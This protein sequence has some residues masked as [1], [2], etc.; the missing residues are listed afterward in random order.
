MPLILLLIALFSC[1]KQE[2]QEP[3]YVPSPYVIEI[4]WRFPA[5]VNIPADNPMTI[6]GVELGRCLF[7]DGR[8]SG[9]TS[10]DSLMSCS[11][12]HLQSH[13][14]EC[15]IDHP[16]FAGGHPFGVTGIP[17]AH[18]M[19]P[20]INLVWTGNGYLWNGSVHGQ[21]ADKNSRNIEDIVSMAIVTPSEMNSDTTRVKTLI[22]NIPGYPELFRKAFGG[23]TV[24]MK[25]ISKAIAQFVRT[26]VSSGSKFD[27]FMKG[28]VQ[29]NSSELSGYVLFMTE[30]GADCFHCH[31]GEGNPLFTA[32][33]YYNNGKD[34][35]FTDVL[36]RSWVTGNTSD[37][38]AYKA[39]TLRNLAFTAPYMHDGRFRTLDEVLDLYNSKL[40]WSP[41]I[42][43][44]MHHIST[45]GVQLTPSKKADLKAFLLTLTD[46][47]FILNPAFSKPE[48]LPGE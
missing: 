29:L 2:T 34:S 14:F 48:K 41:S 19:L 18:S 44:L 11:T 4:P 13:A 17:T 46:S 21:N 40:V 28:E 3:P 9:R 33:L 35:L 30:Q 32:G 12:C 10:P 22:Q 20:L 15:G 39:P 6:E 5:S 47:T 7:Y 16:K 26:L 37:I 23:S 36:D 8:L 24:T 27:R 38:G 45:G 31:G 1:K 42:S 43:P 25:N